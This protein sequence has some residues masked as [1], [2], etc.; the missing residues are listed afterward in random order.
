MVEQVEI[1]VAGP[2]FAFVGSTAFTKS[3][4]PGRKDDNDD[5]FLG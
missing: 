5:E 3:L 4:R 1:F 2:F